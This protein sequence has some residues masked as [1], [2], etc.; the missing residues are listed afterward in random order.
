MH[1]T[2][3]KR[4]RLDAIKLIVTSKEIANQD[5]LLQELR[6]E[7]F[8]LTQATLSRDLKC[9]QVI[10]STNANGKYVY[11]LQG[12][13]P[14]H[15][16]TAYTHPLQEMMDLAGFRSVDFSG[17]LAVI[18]THPGYAA[19]LAYDLDNL[20]LTDI[21]G[22]VAGDDTIILVLREGCSRKS[23]K[24]ALGKITTKS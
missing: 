24:K 13:D 4:Q 16:Q 8:T 6:K 7:G 5:Q 22:S 2:Y 11:V 10:K 9:L 3:N 1:R 14:Q 23:I 21:V 12:N 17:N 18:K 20:G 15:P 19:S